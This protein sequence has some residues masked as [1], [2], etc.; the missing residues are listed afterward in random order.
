[1]LL[2]HWLCDLCVA[3]WSLQVLPKQHADEPAGAVKVVSDGMDARRCS[4]ASTSLV[5]TGSGRAAR[6]TF[7]LLRTAPSE[8][9]PRSCLWPVRIEIFAAGDSHTGPIQK[10][11]PST[12]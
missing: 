7:G 6:V 2:L 11:P 8:G 4:K 10:G 1:M 9:T 12:I 5:H 3:L